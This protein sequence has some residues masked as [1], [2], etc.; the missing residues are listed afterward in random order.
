MAT[1]IDKHQARGNG[2]ASAILPGPFTSCTMRDADLKHVRRLPLFADMAPGHFDAL[3]AGAFLQTFPPRLVLIREGERPDFLYIVVEGTVEAYGALG[4]RETALAILRPYRTFILA[5]VVRDEV[6]LTSARTLEA[7]RILMIPAGAV[8]SV[9][10][11][12]AAFARA[13]VGELASRYRDLV[14]DIKGNKLRTSQ[15]R[16]ANYILQLAPKGGAGKRSATGNP[17]AALELP[18]E[19]RTLASY[20]GMAPEHLSRAFQN[21][22]EHGVTVRGQTVTITDRAK[23]E[24][25]ASPHPLIDERDV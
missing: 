1:T 5:A 2:R 17:V 24:A 22:A 21:L 15:E 9:F 20:L 6:Y 18:V 23:L 8:R 14:R 13:V 19:K 10:D 12:D 3:I 7:T 16:L 11:Q 25:L 4:N